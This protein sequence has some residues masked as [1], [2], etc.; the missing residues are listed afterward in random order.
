MMKDGIRHHTGSAESLEFTYNKILEYIRRDRKQFIALK[1]DIVRYEELQKLFDE[2]K[3][4]PGDDKIMS[5]ISAYARQKSELKKTV[6][7]D[8]VRLRDIARDCVVEPAVKRLFSVGTLSYITE[9]LFVERIVRCQKIAEQRK[10]VFALHGLTPEIFAPMKANLKAFAKLSKESMDLALKRKELQKQR[11]HI[12]DLIFTDLVY[13]CQIGK[14][15]WE[16]DTDKFNDYKYTRYIKGEM[17]FE[18]TENEGADDDFDEILIE[19]SLKQQSK[20]SN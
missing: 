7:A 15:I 4:L 2:Y 17:Y 19:E 20:K 9:K 10:S 14:C 6:I 3:A 12:L 5:D 18:C 13:A 16:S 1:Y 11:N 8:M